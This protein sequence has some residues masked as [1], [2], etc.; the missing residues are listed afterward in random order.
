MNTNS[1]IEIRDAILPED[2]E[3]IKKLWTDY[4]TWGND[5]MQLNYGVHPHN[6]KPQVEK[7]IEMIAKFLPPNGRLILAFIDGNACGIGCLK[8]INDEIGEI[9]RMYVD[10]SFRKIGAGRAIL[11]AL[12]NAAKETGYK[13]VRLDSPKFMEAAHSLYRSF[14]FQPI[15][16]YPEVEIPAEFRQYLLFMEIEL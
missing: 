12:L 5:N 14:G 7:D 1:S 3:H 9:K 6:P 10:P 2:L 11:N 4:L 15:S 8:S 16:A 13:K